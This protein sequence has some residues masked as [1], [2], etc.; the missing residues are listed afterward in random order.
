V[1]TQ[2]GQQAAALG[3]SYPVPTFASVRV[4]YADGSFRE[5]H[6][7]KPVR[8]DITIGGL[9]RGL[10]GLD[11][12]LGA[13]PPGILPPSLPRVEVR[14]EARQDPC[15]PVLTIDSRTADLAGMLG[16]MLALLSEAAD[17]RRMYGSGQDQPVDVWRQW[18]WIAEA[19]LAE[20]GDEPVSA[21]VADVVAAMTSRR[22]GE[23]R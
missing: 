2:P 4:E 8:A 15:H 23:P 1:T 10:P 14:M 17:L 22:D 18:E 6:V 20:L 12:D 13:L 3:Q 9:V 7:H 16:R 11:A 5:F 21:H 19:F